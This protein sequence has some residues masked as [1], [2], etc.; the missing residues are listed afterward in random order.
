MK[1]QFRTDSY[2]FSVDTQSD[3]D[4]SR[5][6]E[7]RNSVKLVN[8]H[9]THKHY[10]KCQGRWGRKNPRYNHRRFTFCPLADAVRWD[11]Y[12]YTR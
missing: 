7:V 6:E 11:V 9:S 8:K 10:V 3:D 1:K 4:M 12:I 2:V 5:L